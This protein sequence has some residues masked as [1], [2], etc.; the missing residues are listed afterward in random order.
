MFKPMK[1]SWG[2]R[3]ALLGLAALSAGLAPIRADNRAVKRELEIIY[4]RSARAHTAKSIAGMERFLREDTTPEFVFQGPR[5]THTR[6]QELE[7]YQPVR[8]GKEPWVPAREFRTRIDRLTVHGDEAI[9]VVTDRA[10]SVVRNPKITGD[11]TGKPHVLTMERTNRDTWIK[12]STGW[13]L[14]RREV[15]S[16]KQ[17]L[18][19]K[20]Y[21]N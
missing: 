8:Q 11:P 20:P 2:A 21:P 10:V 15:V 16:G 4:D 7:T 1:R 3:A 6:Q 14:N 17:T 18:D 19:A 12:T 5:R 9:A 13:K